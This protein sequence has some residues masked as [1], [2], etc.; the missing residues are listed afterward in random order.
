MTFLKPELKLTRRSLMAGVA[1]SVVVSPMVISSQRARA[2]DDQLIVASFGGGW[3]AS[4]TEAFHKPFTEATGI[5]VVVTDGA[6]LAKAKAQV[7]A[8]NIEWDIV[9]LATGW[10]S[11]GARE[12]LWEKIDPTIV[13]TSDAV[14]G[15]Q[16]ENAIGHCTYSSGLAWNAA[17][18]ADGKHPTDWQGFW[19]VKAFPGRRG[20]LTRVTSNLEFALMADGV[21]PKKL[22]PLDVER[23]FKSLDKIKPHVTNWIGAMPQTV[24]LLQNNECDFVSSAAGRIFIAKKQGIPLGYS[25]EGVLIETGRVAVL[26][27]TKKRDLA[28]KHLAFMMR[29]DRQAHFATL[30]GYPPV[31]L[32]GIRLM[33]PELK[34]QSPDPASP[35]NALNDEFW[36]EPNLLALTK[37]FKEWQLV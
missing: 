37:R 6:D 29:P 1:A 8:G 5:K 33:S 31:K 11:A 15:T 20:L 34:S 32:E 2:A 36:W 14:P 18:F 17:K 10:L 30:T 19:D 7:H 25:N 4:M 27:G 28:M 23:A 21:D 22:Y 9:E 16:H 12:N 24:S 3:A 35:K 26:K 13:D